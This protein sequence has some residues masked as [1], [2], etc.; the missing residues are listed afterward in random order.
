VRRMIAAGAAM[1]VMA[2]AGASAA[3]ATEGVATAAVGTKTEHLSFASTQQTGAYSVIGTGAFTDGGV[4][5]VLDGRATLTLQRGT[6]KMTIKS[7]KPS[8][9]LS[10]RTCLGVVTQS[11]TY[12]LVGGTGAY[13]GIT[14]SGGYVAHDTEVGQIKHGTCSRTAAPV[15]VQLLIRGDGPVS[16]R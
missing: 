11:G 15:A 12:R 14:G 6:I 3:I 16:L 13:A 9:S 4:A 8:R 1:T 5:Q 2:A 10:L 7:G